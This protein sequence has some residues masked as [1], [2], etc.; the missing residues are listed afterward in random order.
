MSILS[1]YRLP[2]CE[3]ATYPEI[4]P[5]NGVRAMAAC[6]LDQEFLPIEDISRWITNEGHRE[7][8]SLEG[9]LP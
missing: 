7:V 9:V 1:A 5:V 2:G 6:A 3:G 4:T 8:T